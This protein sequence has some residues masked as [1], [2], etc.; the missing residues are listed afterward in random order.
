MNSTERTAAMITYLS[1]LQA[2]LARHRG[3]AGPF[4]VSIDVDT[5]RANVVVQLDSNHR[6]TAVAGGL[7]AWADSLT[8]VTAEAWRPRSGDTVHLSVSGVI[9]GVSVRA[10]DATPLDETVF[11]DLAAGERRLITLG[12]LR[13]WA[14]GAGVAA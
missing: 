12:Q 5:V 11:G 10:Y 9:G 7:L 3:L 13:S 8:E 14:T 1:T 6:L 2:H 4:N